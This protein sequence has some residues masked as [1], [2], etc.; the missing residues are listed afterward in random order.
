MLL[1]GTFRAPVSSQDPPLAGRNRAS[2][3][4]IF[5]FALMI[6]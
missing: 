6:F 4:L 1:A 3:W 2:V 5:H